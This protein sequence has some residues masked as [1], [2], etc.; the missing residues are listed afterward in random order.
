MNHILFIGARIGRWTLTDR[1][2]S[3]PNHRHTRW[4]CLCDCG[5]TRTVFSSSLKR[6]I[7]VSCGCFRSEQLSKNRA[8][9]NN[10]NWN[11]GKTI[12]KQ[13]YIKILVGSN[14]YDLEHRIVMER[15]LG[16]KLFP[17]ETVHHKTASVQTIHLRILNFGSGLSIPKGQQ[18]K[19]C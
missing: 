5:A 13:G 3:D 18:S 14:N 16:R 19:N 11:G 10:P 1:A 15:L 7:S 12:T 8:K 9:E 4:S 6:G 17:D 2:T